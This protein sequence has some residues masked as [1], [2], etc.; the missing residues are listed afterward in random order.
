MSSALISPSCDACVSSP[1]GKSAA[2][3]I[4]PAAETDAGHPD[5]YDK[6]FLLEVIVYDLLWSAMHVGTLATLLT[7]FTRGN[8][9]CTLKTWHHLLSDNSQAM[10]LGLRYSPEI[11]LTQELSA[12]TS[13]LYREISAAKL[14]LESLMKAS[15]AGSSERQ[16]KAACAAWA[17]LAAETKSILAVFE[18]TVL[19][20]FDKTLLDDA[21][22]LLQFLD[23]AIVGNVKRVNAY[24]EITFPILKQMR[25]EPR[26]EIDGQCTISFGTKSLQ[27]ALKDISASGLGVLCD[28]RLPDNQVVTVLLEGGRQLKAE[29][30]NQSGKRLG[31]LFRRK[32]DRD[33]LLLRRRKKA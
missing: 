10:Q 8:A 32:L 7:A 23:E 15:S 17:R 19:R 28:Q 30:A 9:N 14:R 18:A 4:A 33:D 21:R 26:L 6:D 13:K 16:L 24:G 11:G 5:E 29:V 1:A 22:T 3:S 25:H 27:A 2:R 31:L 12:N 20:V